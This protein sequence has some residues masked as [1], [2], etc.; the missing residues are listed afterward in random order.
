MSDAPRENGYF[1]IAD[2]RL[3]GVGLTPSELA[4][5]DCE[6]VVSHLATYA[7]LFARGVHG[8]ALKGRDHFDLLH[9]E[10]V[11]FQPGGRFEFA[12]DLLN[13]SDHTLAIIIPAPDEWGVTIDLVAWRLDTGEL[14]TWRGAAAMLGEDQINAPR[15]EADGLRV[16]AEPAEWLRAERHGVVVLDAER[17]R[18]RLARERLIA[19]DKEFGLCVRDML[20]LPEPQ[21]FV[22]MG[23]AA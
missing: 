15:I 2:P 12:R 1:A 21:V 17:A 8:Q 18:W 23:A 14:A 4:L 16:F 11:C 9:C 22:D 20:R 6:L 3:I 5:L 7:A 10:A 19:S 13:A